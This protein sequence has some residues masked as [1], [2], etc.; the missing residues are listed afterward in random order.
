LLNSIE[1]PNEQS[2]PNVASGALEIDQMNNERHT[3]ES[4]D[5]RED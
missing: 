3:A 4:P 2:N 5:D 1:K